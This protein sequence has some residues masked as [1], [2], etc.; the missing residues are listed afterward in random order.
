MKI[1][2]SIVNIQHNQL[3]NIV[4]ERTATLKEIKN[5]DFKKHTRML[6]EEAFMPFYTYGVG[7]MNQYCHIHESYSENEYNNILLK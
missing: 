2:N 5:I 1:K 4:I 7:C 6:A 3:P